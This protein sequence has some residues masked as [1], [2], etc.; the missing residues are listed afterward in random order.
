MQQI[1][2]MRGVFLLRT[3]RARDIWRTG[4]EKGERAGVSGKVSGGARCLLMLYGTGDQ[5]SHP[6][7]YLEHE[8]LPFF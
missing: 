4:E 1:L 5:N 6:L 8:K 3:G 7:K 2:K